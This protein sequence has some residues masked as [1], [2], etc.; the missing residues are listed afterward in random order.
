MKKKRTSRNC[1]D[2]GIGQNLA[3]FVKIHK[4]E[5]LNFF[6]IFYFLLF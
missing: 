3:E 2:L 5:S 1:K 4:L 6:F